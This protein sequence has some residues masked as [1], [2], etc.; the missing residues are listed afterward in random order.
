MPLVSLLAIHP[1]PY[2]LPGYAL[3]IHCYNGECLYME[4]L[5]TWMALDPNPR[6]V[7]VAS[8]A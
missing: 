6:E 4:E 7:N 2:H 3:L 1:L 8:V 5:R